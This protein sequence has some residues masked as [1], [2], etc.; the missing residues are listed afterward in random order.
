MKSAPHSRK[1][2]PHGF[3]R[4]LA[5]AAAL[6][7]VIALAPEPA[8]AGP[9]IALAE[10]T[11]DFGMISPGE[12]SV[13]EILLANSGDAPLIVTEIVAHDG[14]V[15]GGARAD[16]IAPGDS[17]HIVVVA[18]PSDS[19]ALET[20]LVV[21][22][23]DPQEPIA[24]VIVRASVARWHDID[25]S[26]RGLGEARAGARDIAAIP[27]RFRAGTDLR[28]SGSSSTL[29]FLELEDRPTADSTQRYVA[30][31]IAPSAAPGPFEGFVDLWIAGSHP[32]TVRIAVRGTVVTQ[33][34]VEPNPYYAALTRFSKS[35]PPPIRCERVAT[36]PARIVDATSTL[37]GWIA[38]L[39][40]IEE[41]RVYQITLVPEGESK[42]GL[43]TGEVRITTSD[44]K[45]PLVI[46][47]ASILVG[48][49]RTP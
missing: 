2:S 18:T 37:S 25:T 23:N 7:L 33:W 30:I 41:G 21:R 10:R 49:A 4:G 47:P 39:A 13:R 44:K 26:V 38:R 17:T 43:A 27:Y 29:S 12:H 6:V 22:T 35:Q 40:T 32:D 16:T 1:R 9:R 45:Q 8:L 20:K 14:T 36:S 11:L 31:S 5:C 24:A 46:V 15:R 48:K 19:G 34:R 42:A 3:E 28:L